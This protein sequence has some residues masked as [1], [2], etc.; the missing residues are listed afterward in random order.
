MQF[1]SVFHALSHL[2]VC[3]CVWAV[4]G[5]GC[6]KFTP[7][8]LCVFVYFGTFVITEN[9]FHLFDFMCVCVYVGSNSAFIS[10]CLETFEMTVLFMCV[11]FLY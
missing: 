7:I 10:Q 1:L 5:C 2:C 4:G 6:C 11:C 9:Y 8:D 3:V